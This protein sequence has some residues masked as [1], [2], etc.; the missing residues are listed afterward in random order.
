MQWSKQ[1]LAAQSQRND[2]A[3]GTFTR[4]TLRQSAQTTNLDPILAEHIHTARGDMQPMITPVT[5]VGM[6]LVGTHV[7]LTC[8]TLPPNIA[9]SAALLKNNQFAELT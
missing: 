1:L 5:N 3:S 4:V 9:T 8:P 7:T 6:A 2:K